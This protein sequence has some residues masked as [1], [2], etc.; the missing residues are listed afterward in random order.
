VVAAVGVLAAVV[1]FLLFRPDKL[2]VDDKVDEQL[3]DDVAALVDESTTSPTTTTPP[4][5]G[6][7]TTPPST[8]APATT[9]VPTTAVP[10]TAVP[11][12]GGPRLLGKGEFISLD[13]PTT[14]TAAI[15]ETDGRLELVIADLATENGPDLKV[16]LSPRSSDAAGDAAYEEDAINLG[17]LKGNI[18]TQTYEIPAGTDVASIKSVAI[19]C[20]RFSVGFGVAPVAS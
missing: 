4:T 10:T 2:F 20:Q 19:W 12:T 18:G 1:G 11:T 6:S 13:H 15:V 9:A 17:P 8:E 3:S 16:Y 5:T 14:G 7:A